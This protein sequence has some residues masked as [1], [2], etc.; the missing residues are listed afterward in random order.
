MAGRY[1]RNAD[2][3]ETLECNDV[4]PDVQTLFQ[5]NVRFVRHWTAILTN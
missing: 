4:Q 1:K 2:L 5:Y 3:K